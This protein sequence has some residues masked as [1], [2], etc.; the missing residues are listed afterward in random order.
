MRSR[1]AKSVASP[2]LISA[3]IGSTR[4]MRPIFES[5]SANIAASHSSAMLETSGSVRTTALTRHDGGSMTTRFKTW[6]PESRGKQVTRSTHQPLTGVEDRKGEIFWFSPP[7]MIK[8]APSGSDA[9]RQQA[10]SRHY[11][12]P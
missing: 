3:R 12:K 7:A 1:F 9:Y 11:G 10:T 8:F 5:K 2:L 4:T 6:R